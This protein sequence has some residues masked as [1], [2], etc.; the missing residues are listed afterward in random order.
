MQNQEL[1]DLHAKAMKAA[2]RAY[3][4]YSDFRVGA[5]LLCE[6]GSVVV[7]VNV[8]NRSYGLTICAERSA[9]SQAVS[10][11]YRAFKALAIATPDST[12]PVPPCGACRQVISE[13]AAPGMPIVFGPNASSL[14][15][16]TSG[17]LYPLDSLHELASAS[18]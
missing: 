1:A 3:A 5:A 14:V 11:G 10:L 2:E 15:E 6:D 4:P 17:Q 7:G 13:F 16:S 9:I 8:E 18:T 12:G